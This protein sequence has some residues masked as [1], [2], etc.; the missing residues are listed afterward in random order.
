MVKWPRRKK[1]VSAPPGEP[2]VRY[3]RFP[4]ALVPGNQIELLVDGEKAYP[5]MLSAIAGAKRTVLMGS[6]IFHDDKVGR[7]FAEKLLM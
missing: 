7:V 6:Y 1:R 4:D 5:A 2:W 3:C